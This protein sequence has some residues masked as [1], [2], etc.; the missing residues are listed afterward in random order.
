MSFIP[1]IEQAKA[2]GT[3][4]YQVFSFVH[5]ALDLGA[6][7]WRIWQTWNDPTTSKIEKAVYITLDGAGILANTT[8]LANA[9]HPN[10][11]NKDGKNLQ[12]IVTVV[13]LAGDARRILSSENLTASDVATLSTKVLL[14]AAQQ[15]NGGEP[16][17]NLINA[18][19]TIATCYLDREQTYEQISRAKNMANMLFEHIK[20]RLS[21]NQENNAQPNQSIQR[22]PQ[23]EYEAR[24]LLVQKTPPENNQIRT[25]LEILKTVEKY[26]DELVNSTIDS[27]RDNKSIIDQEDAS[28][29]TRIPVILSDREEFQ[30]MKCRITSS[31]I[32]EVVIIS[33][34]DTN[35]PIYY[36]FSTLK[37]VYDGRKNREKDYL[38]PGWPKSIPFSK[39]FTQSDEEKTEIITEALNQAILNPAVQRLAEL[40]LPEYDKEKKYY[41]KILEICKKEI[42]LLKKNTKS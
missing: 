37:A 41:E 1:S 5:N 15:Y 31:P 32:R 12:K 22:D 33:K 20:K 35:T 38:P 14:V 34:P 6:R 8:I 40:V 2:T 28:K 4:L 16:L 25:E 3:V 18:S 26:Y 24:V 11:D 9:Y 42:S 10:S 17:I 29:F 19:G 13:A 39:K 23:A 21:Q 7:S 27:M 30:K 36:E